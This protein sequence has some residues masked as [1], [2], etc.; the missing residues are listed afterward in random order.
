MLPSTAIE[1]EQFG[2]YRD[3]SA[4]AAEDLVDKGVETAKEVAADAYQTVKE[5]ADRQGLKSTG[6][7]V[8]RR[9]GWQG[10]EVDC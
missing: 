1:D 9:P 4:S 3:K 6:G 8:G 5:E 10:G 2:R 7:L